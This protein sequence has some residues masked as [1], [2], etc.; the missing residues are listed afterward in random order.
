[1]TVSPPLTLNVYSQKDHSTSKVISTDFYKMGPNGN[2]ELQITRAKQYGAGGDNALIDG[3][4]GTED[5]RTG[6]WQGYSDTD[7]VKMETTLFLNLGNARYVKVLADKLGKLPKWHLGAS[8]NG[9]AL[10]KPLA[11]R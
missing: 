7:D 6:T 9:S 5:F 3:I 11:I 4:L 2:I 8:Y 10:K 1:M